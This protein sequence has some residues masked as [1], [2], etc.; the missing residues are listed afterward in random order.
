MSVANKNLSRH[1]NFT[2][3]LIA[4]CSDFRAEPTCPV[5]TYAHCSDPPAVSSCLVMEQR[6]ISF[7]PSV[8]K[9]ILLRLRPGDSLMLARHFSNFG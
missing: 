5:T 1:S 4:V 8:T 7:R 9:A 3:V 6:L 2:N